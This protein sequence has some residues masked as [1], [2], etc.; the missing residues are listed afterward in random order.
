MLVQGQYSWVHWVLYVLPRGREVDTGV[1]VDSLSFTSLH[2]EQL[3]SPRVL[4]DTPA[5]S[6][7]GLGSRHGFARAGRVISIASAG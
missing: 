7:K 6:D 2:S 3:G 4:R 1:E 5:G